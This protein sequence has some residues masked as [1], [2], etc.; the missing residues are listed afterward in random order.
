MVDEKG[1]RLVAFGRMAGVAGMH[2]CPTY[3]PL[4]GILA[5]P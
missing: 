5:Y 3:V 2:S 1:A 4:S